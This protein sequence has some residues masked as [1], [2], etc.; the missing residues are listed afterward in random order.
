MA[1]DIADFARAHIKRRAR[2]VNMTAGRIVAVHALVALLLG[3]S[4]YDVV[5]GQE[6]WPFSPYPMFSSV[7]RSRT[8][9]SLLLVGV[10]AD[11]SGREFPLR[12]A[13]YI[14]PFD[15]CRLNTALQRARSADDHG[16]RLHA[17][18]EDSMAR[19]ATYRPQSG[20]SRRR[21]R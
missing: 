19:P 21:S 3:A 12:E 11:A 4:S 9:D 8:L 20:P 17:M 2:A 1:Q 15:Q 18:L 10:V 7:E 6:H 16:G 5:T 13:A 14:A